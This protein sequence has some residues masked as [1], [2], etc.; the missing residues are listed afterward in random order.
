MK[1][2]TAGAKVGY[3]TFIRFLESI[4]GHR[5]A[6]FVCI[7]GKIIRRGY[8]AMVKKSEH[9]KSCGCMDKPSGRK[10]HNIETTR[11]ETSIDKVMAIM[12]EI[13]L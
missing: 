9:P 3:L 1:D 2:L 6:E 5:R 7:C 12:K 11:R 10:K 8:A 4:N 13:W